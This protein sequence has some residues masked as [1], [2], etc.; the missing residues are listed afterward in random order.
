[1]NKIK[2]LGLKRTN[3]TT[4]SACTVVVLIFFFIYIYV[5]LVEFA[6]DELSFL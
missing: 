3:A 4:F 2:D 6:S 1:M 5:E